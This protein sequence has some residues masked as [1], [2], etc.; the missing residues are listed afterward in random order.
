MN[1][2][3]RDRTTVTD[4]DLPRVELSMKEIRRQHT[5]LLKAFAKH[6][7]FDATGLTISI[8]VMVEN[9]LHEFN[10]LKDLIQWSKE[11]PKRKAPDSLEL[12]YSFGKFVK[13]KRDG[14][15]V[16]MM[17][18][19]LILGENGENVCHVSSNDVNWLEQTREIVKDGMNRCG[20]HR[21]GQILRHVGF[22]TAV[23]GILLFLVMMSPIDS[24]IS[25]ATVAMFVV[26]AAIVT[27]P[28]DSY[29]FKK[30]TANIIRL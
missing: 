22:A 20:L 9:Q 25:L 15:E 13:T 5:S 24:G 2:Y 8:R 17:N 18:V 28:E 16:L 1:R 6:E 26:G 21:Y 14:G 23:I 10:S 3:L 19:N 12:A 4:T 27:W 30:L 11:C 7:F 29:L